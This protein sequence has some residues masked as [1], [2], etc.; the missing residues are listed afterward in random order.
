[1]DD[2]LMTDLN[3]GHADSPK[4][5]AKVSVSYLAGGALLSAILILVP[6][7]VGLLQGKWAATLSIVTSSLLL[8]VLVGAAGSIPLGFDPYSGALIAA[9]SNLAPVPLLLV[10]FD[11]IAE[12]WKWFQRRM[13]KA[14]KWS[15]K[16]GKY[17]VWVL[18][19]LAPFL[20]AYV[21]VAIGI[22]LRWRP[23][24]I[25]ATISLGVIVSAFLTTFGGNLL[26]G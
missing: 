12:E 7:L 19:P 8:E 14:A 16:Y 26:F 11:T 3:P 24:L 13:S 6:F 15:A 10:L 5:A 22:G 21:C 23:V 9:C 1:M 4:A 18:A 17:G 20:G 2:K 25:F